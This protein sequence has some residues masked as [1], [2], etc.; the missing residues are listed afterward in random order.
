MF[1][2]RVLTLFGLISMLSVCILREWA[3]HKEVA[4]DTLS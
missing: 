4:Q 2:A 1:V 3:G